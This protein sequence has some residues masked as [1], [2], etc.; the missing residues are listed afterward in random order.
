VLQNFCPKFFVSDILFYHTSQYST[1][2]F[3]LSV[4]RTYSLQNPYSI[5]RCIMPFHSS[6]LG[7][8]FCVPVSSQYVII[9]I[10]S[11]NNH[12][13]EVTSPLVLTTRPYVNIVI[14]CGKIYFHLRL[15]NSWLNSAQNNGY[16]AWTPMYIYDYIAY[17]SVLRR[18]WN[19]SDKSCREKQ[20]TFYI[21]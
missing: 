6:R 3:L 4:N 13:A 12:L 15:G 2:P 19:I 9:L 5:F 7:L 8:R 17:R 10:F 1:V 14:H 16:F 11:K 20:N 18:M 21:Q